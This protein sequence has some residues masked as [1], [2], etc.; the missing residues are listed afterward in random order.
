MNQLVLHTG[1]KETQGP[2]LRSGRRV[3]APGPLGDHTLGDLE[4]SEAE[5]TVSCPLQGSVTF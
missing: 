2:D 5:V 4:F 1:H 3:R